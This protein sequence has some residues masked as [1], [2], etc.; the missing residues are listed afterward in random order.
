MTTFKEFWKD[1]VDRYRQNLQV[2]GDKVYSYG[3]HV[4]TIKGDK[5]VR[6]GWWSVTTSKHVN[7]VAQQLG[8]TVVDD[9]EGEG[10]KG[11]WE[12][13]QGRRYTLAELKQANPLFFSR[14]TMR[15]FGS[16]RFSI[17]GDTLVITFT[18]DKVP[19]GASRT[20]RYS[21][22]PKTLELNHISD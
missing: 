9:K 18:S 14:D 17:Q 22:D 21:I 13:A 20:A 5:L 15:F 11:Y 16:Q 7:Y 4:A 2:V 8:L 6:H 1:S 3:T 19:E 12:K 10:M